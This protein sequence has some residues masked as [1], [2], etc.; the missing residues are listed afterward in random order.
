MQKALKRNDKDGLTPKQMKV[1]KMIKTFIK[2]NGYSPSYEELKQLIGSKS[3]SH[4]H[5]LVHQLIRRGW[6]GK[7]NGRNRSIFIL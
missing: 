1:Y 7:G 2:A 4:V 6:I 5:G 3:K